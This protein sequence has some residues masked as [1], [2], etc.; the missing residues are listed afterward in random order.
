MV[1]DLPGM[2]AGGW[3]WRFTSKLIYLPSTGAKVRT[4]SLLELIFPLFH[5]RPQ[6]VWFTI[7]LVFACVQKQRHPVETGKSTLIYIE[8]SAVQRPDSSL[9]A[10]HHLGL[11]ESGQRKTDL[12]ENGQRPP[13]LQS[14]DE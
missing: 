8:G 11:G 10:E 1:H 4:I 7:A 2:L 14:W 3:G 13:S 5:L 12:P 6:R 9:R